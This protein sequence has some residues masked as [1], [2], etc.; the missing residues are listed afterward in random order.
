M[1]KIAQIEKML[2]VYKTQIKE[3]EDSIQVLCGQ[4]EE[5]LRHLKKLIA[6][7]KDYQNELKQLKG[8]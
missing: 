5:Q 6:D 7:E 1:E 2:F 4:L 3:C 8:N